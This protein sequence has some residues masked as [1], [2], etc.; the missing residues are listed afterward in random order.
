MSDPIDFVPKPLRTIIFALAAIGTIV[1]GAVS[2][3]SLVE[4]KANAAASSAVAPLKIQVDQ[5]IERSNEVAA[6]QAQLWDKLGGRLDKLDDKLDTLSATVSG[7][8]ATQASQAQAVQVLAS[9]HG[10]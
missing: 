6:A 10:K 2:T 4:N 3:L 1:T 8:A 5:A 7:L 9:K